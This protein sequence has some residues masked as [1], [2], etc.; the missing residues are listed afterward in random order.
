MT[1]DSNGNVLTR[2]I[3]AGGNSRTWTYTYDANGAVLTVDGPRTDVTDVTTYT[4]YANSATCPGAAALGCRGQVETVTNAAGH[5]TSI[6]EYDAHGRPLAIVDPNGLTTDLVYDPRQRLTSRNV[7]GE[8]TDYE[9]DGVGQL[10]KVTLPDGSFLSYTYDAAHR[11]TQ[12]TD[13][14]GNR[15][16]YTLDAMG[17]RTKEEVFDTTNTLKRTLTRVYET[18]NRLIYE[19][20]P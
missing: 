2:T 13:N 4:Y 11:L 8:T 20:H 19:A 9:Y 1:H 6:A 7:G 14:A 18:L 3:T 10:K 16:A 17:N 12:V 15:I 5:V